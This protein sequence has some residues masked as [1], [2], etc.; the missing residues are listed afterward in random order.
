MIFRFDLP[1]H[2]GAEQ[3]AEHKAQAVL[4]ADRA[5]DPMHRDPNPDWLIDRIEIHAP[6]S[7][8]WV[9]VPKAHR[10][11]QLAVNYLDRTKREVED[12]WARFLAAYEREVA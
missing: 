10:L 4:V 11:H 9:A 5:N 1:E 8:K 2:I 6:W 7:G 3:I 12:E